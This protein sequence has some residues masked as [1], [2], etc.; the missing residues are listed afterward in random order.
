[1]DK[2]VS[3]LAEKVRDSILGY[4]AFLNEWE[5][6]VLEE[7]GIITLRGRV[8]T[9]KYREAMEK[10]AQNQ[11]GVVSVLNQVDVD[12]SLMEDE[13]ELEMN[14]KIPLIP[15]RPFGQQ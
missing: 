1:M 10:I 5:L 2:L 11:E 6:V 7:N 13:T 15:Q 9:A 8:P 14:A 4:E 12:S 3:S